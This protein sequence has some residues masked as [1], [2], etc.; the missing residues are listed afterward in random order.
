MPRLRSANG[1]RQP[2]F[3]VTQER[4]QPYHLQVLQAILQ[5]RFHPAE[6]SQL[7]LILQMIIHRIQGHRDHQDHRGHK[8]HQGQQDI[9]DH[10][11]T[12]DLQDLQDRQA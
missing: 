10:E 2:L 4:P 9:R 8:D 3:Q 11:A 5:T 6:E 1:F 7:H 12:M